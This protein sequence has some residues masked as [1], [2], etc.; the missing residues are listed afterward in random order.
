MA[1]ARS[2]HEDEPINREGAHHHTHTYCFICAL[3]CCNCTFA[4]LANA[5]ANHSSHLS[6]SHTNSHTTKRLY[7][8]RPQLYATCSSVWNHTNT[9]I[10]RMRCTSHVVRA[11]VCLW[12]AADFHRQRPLG[13][14]GKTENCVR[15]DDDASI[16]GV[17]FHLWM[18]V[19]AVCAN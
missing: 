18:D 11:S 9:I 14:G 13:C 16:A 4:D 10:D 19:A 3:C 15:T 5:I 6:Q 12:R 8:V 2:R 1:F 17:L 7:V